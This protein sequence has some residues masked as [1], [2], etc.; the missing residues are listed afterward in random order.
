MTGNNDT[1][2]TFRRQRNGNTK[3][4]TGDLGNSTNTGRER[5]QTPGE[6][7]RSFSGDAIPI[8]DIPAGL[9][10]MEEL[11]E[12]ESVPLNDA[13]MVRSTVFLRC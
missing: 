5:W 2:S 1:Q 13:S 8:Q 10:D 9:N 6:L 3:S 11:G 12:E 7:S 4:S